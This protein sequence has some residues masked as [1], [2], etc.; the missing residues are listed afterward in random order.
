M[1]CIPAAPSPRELREAE[2]NAKRQAQRA[3][4]AAALEADSALFAKD[5]LEAA[6]KVQFT[7]GSDD[8]QG[9]MREHMR[10]VEDRYKRFQGMVTGVT[11][12]Y[13]IKHYYE[14]ISRQ[15]SDLDD[16]EPLQEQLQQKHE[17][18]RKE[19][20]G[21]LGGLCEQ[22]LKNPAVNARGFRESVL[23]VFRELK[24]KPEITNIG[25]LRD[26]AEAYAKSA[27]ADKERLMQEAWDTFCAKRDQ[28][29]D[30]FFKAVSRNA[31]AMKPKFDEWVAAHNAAKEQGPLLGKVKEGDWCTIK[32]T[33]TI[34]YNNGRE[35]WRCAEDSFSQDF[36][37]NTGANL[38]WSDFVKGEFTKLRDAYAS[39]VATLLQKYNDPESGYSTTGTIPTTGAWNVGRVTGRG[40]IT[41]LTYSRVTGD[42]DRFARGRFHND[43]ER[44]EY[45]R[46]YDRPV[47]YN[48]SY[49]TMTHISLPAMDVAVEGLYW[50]DS[51]NKSLLSYC[52]Y[53]GKSSLEGLDIEKLKAEA[54]EGL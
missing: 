6:A 10:E 7:K 18:R 40:N 8:L 46:R 12:R 21:A 25:E 17:A 34:V 5:T 22:L 37:D 16:S 38:E 27:E 23:D 19:L 30:K 51:D 50:S 14:N 29:R 53:D 9:T 4:K 35:A 13:P 52:F 11:G 44:L 47:E 15:F 31:A 1:G 48:G 2:Q 32:P 28:A 45:M 42:E 20:D 26:K 33:S 41:H 36:P 43:H 39:M 54:M 49:W 3:E 24:D